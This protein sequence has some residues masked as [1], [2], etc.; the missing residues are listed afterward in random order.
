MVTDVGFQAFMLRHERLSERSF[1]DAMWTTRFVRSCL[2]GIL[3]FSVADPLGSWLQKP[4]AIFA[5]QI[6]S[7]TFFIDGLVPIS[8]ITG[9]VGDRLRRYCIIDICMSISNFLICFSWAW[10]YPNIYSLIYASLANQ[11]IRVALFRVFLPDSFLVWAV[12]FAVINDVLKFGRYIAA[13]SLITVF[14]IQVD[15]LGLSRVLETDRL[16]AYFLAA[17]IAALPRG[18]ASAISS[19]SLYPAFSKFAAQRE[20]LDS[21]ELY[22][23]RRVLDKVFP[24]AC[25]VRSLLSAWF[26]SFLY[27]PRYR[28]AG[29]FLEILFFGFI[30]L[31]WNLAINEFLVARGWT[32]APFKANV[33]RLVWLLVI[34][35][36]FLLNERIIMFLTLAALIEFVTYFYL[37]VKLWRL[38]FF[39]LRSEI[40][41]IVFALASLVML[42]FASLRSLGGFEA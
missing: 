4:E 17:N 24:T 9:L 39:R 18:L 7:L 25:L 10:I 29:I 21:S 38:G 11:L 19:K 16:G 23:S 42:G 5:L 31:M 13:S 37:I 26:I 2:L 20:Y 30:P 35:L 1:R 36:P 32:S 12:D 33:V 41:C 8:N 3:F 27:D 34:A 14:I 22:K 28:E 15:K 40:F 6:F